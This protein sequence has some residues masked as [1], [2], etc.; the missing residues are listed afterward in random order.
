MAT[1]LIRNSA[2]ELLVFTGQAGEHSIEARY[3]EAV[4]SV[5]YRVHSV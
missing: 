1:K 5:G 2:A 4:I 3:E